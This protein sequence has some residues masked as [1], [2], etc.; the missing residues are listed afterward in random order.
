L[1]NILPET[2]DTHTRR[3]AKTINFG[4]IYGM[5]AQSLSK[6]LSIA[7]QKARF[8]I[9]RYMERFSKAKEFIDQTLKEAKDLGYT[10]T[11]F[12]RRR[13]FENINSPNKKLSEFEKRA[14]VNAKIQGTAADIIKIA[15]VKLDEALRGLDAKIVLQIHDELLIECKDNLIEE[16]KLIVKDSME[17]AVNFDVPLKVNIGVG[18]NWHEAKA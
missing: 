5:G 9:Q 4:I 10:Q 18:K 15:M 6:T 3:V 12:N 1:F 16:I 2:V 13:Y 14:A 8:Y 11:Y 7:P 17:K